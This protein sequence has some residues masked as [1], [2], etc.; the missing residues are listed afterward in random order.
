MTRTTNS[1]VTTTPTYRRAIIQPREITHDTSF[2]VRDIRDDHVR[3]LLTALRTTGRLDPV[4]LW[5]D[6][7]DPERPRLVL[8]DGQHRLAA[9][10]NDRRRKSGTQ[11]IPARIVSCDEVMAH[12]LA[13]QRNS[14]DKLPLTCAEKMNLAWRLV[15]LADAQLSKADIMNDTGVG[16]TTVH[17]M[18][19]RRKAMIAAGQEP[20]GE[21]WRDRKDTPL[22]QP[23]EIDMEARI[24]DLAEALKRPAEAMRREPAEVK[25]RVLERVLGTYEARQVAWRGL[26]LDY[27][28]FD[29]EAHKIAPITRDTGTDGDTDF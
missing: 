14:R 20:T 18:R 5:D 1:P 29:E 4:L 28:E 11:G 23:E 6:Q 3:T 9:Y 10:H 19:V 15:W 22:D 24:A 27:D 2:T 25:W 16:R 13:A 7:R 26:Q 17:N 8:L 12:R 21:W